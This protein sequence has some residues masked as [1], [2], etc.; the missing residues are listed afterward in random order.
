MPARKRD[1]KVKHSRVLVIDASVM[2]AAGSIDA[3]APVPARCRDTL[4]TVLEVCHR[5]HLDGDLK[6][7]WNRHMSKFARTWL[8]S[9]YSRRKIVGTGS[10][11]QPNLE[12]MTAMAASLPEAQRAAIEK[13]L[14]LVACAILA[15]GTILSLDDA[16]NRIL[17]G[18]AVSLPVLRGLIWVNPSIDFG[19]LKAWLEETGPSDPRWCLNQRNSA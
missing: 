16:M 6:E 15:D 2:R 19:K 8:R 7:E 5:A 9:M 1:Q 14:H 13:D 11:A 3:T 10:A 4:R 12:R 17:R 18:L